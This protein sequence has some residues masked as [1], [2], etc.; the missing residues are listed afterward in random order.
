L[1]SGRPPRDWPLSNGLQ[2]T[3]CALYPAVAA[4]LQRLRAAGAAQPLMSGSGSTVYALFDGEDDARRVHDR[5]VARGHQAI[6]T[7]MSSS[8][9]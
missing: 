8:A 2:D 1:R 7:R 5:L 4:A 6:L 9:G 3:V